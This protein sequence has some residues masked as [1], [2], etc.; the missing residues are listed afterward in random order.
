MGVKHDGCP[1]GSRKPDKSMP[2]VFSQLGNC[3][4]PDIYLLSDQC[5]YCNCIKNFKG[6]FLIWLSS[7]SFFK[8]IFISQ[9]FRGHGKI[10]QMN[11]VKVFDWLVIRK[12]GWSILKKNTMCLASKYKNLTVCGKRYEHC[13]KAILLSNFKGKTGPAHWEWLGYM[14][15]VALIMLTDASC[16]AQIREM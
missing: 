7:F 16:G 5:R 9:R 15:L 6:F 12:W 11:V 1:T 10:I 13:A 8:T 3:S 14:Q 2:Q 4:N